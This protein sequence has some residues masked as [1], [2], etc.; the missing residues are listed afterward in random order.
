M[1]HIAGAFGE[2]NDG[3]VA[4]SETRLDGAT[5]HVTLPVTHMGLLISRNVADQIGAFLKRG[6]FLR[7]SE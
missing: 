3:T 6:E 7:D 5:D 1:G 2:P 4:V